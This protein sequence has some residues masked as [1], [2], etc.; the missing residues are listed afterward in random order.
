MK[1]KL[2]DFE[3]EKD[4]EQAVNTFLKDKNE[5]IEIQ[6]QTSHFSFGNEQIFSFSCLILYKG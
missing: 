2:F 6:Y 1:V 5:I 3:H 4:L